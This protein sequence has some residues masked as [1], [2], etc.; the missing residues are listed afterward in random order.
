MSDPVFETVSKAKRQ[1]E[2][3][4]PKAA[5]ETLEKFLSENPLSIPPRM[6]LA[7]LYIYRLGDREFGITQLDVI[8]DMDP[9]NIDALKAATTVMMSDKKYRFRVNEDYTRLVG[10][11]AARKDPKEFAQVCAAYAV[12]LRRQMVDFPKSGEYYEKAIAAV[13]D[14]YEYHQDYAVL[15]LN[16]L[17][18]Y[19]KA[20]TELEEVLR[21]KPNSISARKNYDL[22]MKTKYDKDGNLKKPTFFSRFR[23]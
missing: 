11:V 14:A 17:K 2:S 4:N 21:L 13:P 1:E 3:G 19:P 22:L 12:F 8:L 16:D 10:L 6:E 7:R 9:D 5:A 18:D 15:L 23:H 20:K